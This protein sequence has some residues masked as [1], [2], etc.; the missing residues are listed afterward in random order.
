MAV[1]TAEV[2]TYEPRG[3]VLDAFYCHDKEV[4]L[5][6]PAGTGKTLGTLQKLHLCAAHRYPGCR[7]LIMRKTLTSLTRSALVTFQKTVKPHLDGV[8]FFG[9][10]ASKPPAFQYPNGSEIVV[11]GMDKPEN[12]LSAEYDAV[13]INQA[14]ELDESE[15]EFAKM[16]LRPFAM[17]YAQ[18]VGDCNPAAPTHWIKRRAER[19]IIADE[20][21][22]EGQRQL[23]LLESRHQDNPRY[24]DAAAQSWTDEGRSYV[25]GTLGSLTGVRALRY[26][27]GL[28]AAA[29]GL[30]YDGWEPSVNLIAPFD[31]PADWGRVW[32][33][34]FGYVHA[35][36]WQE[37]R[38]DG[39]G[40]MYR[41]KEIHM[42]QRLVADHAL[43]IARAAGA[44]VNAEAPA[45]KRID[46]TGVPRP[47]SLV[48]DHDAED[49][50]TLER[51]LG[52]P[53][54]PA[55][56]AIGKGVQAFAQRLK[57]AGDGRPRLMFFRDALVELDQSAEQAKKP[58]CTEQEVDGYVWPTP[59]AVSR[60]ADEVPVKKDDDGLDAARYAVMHEDGGHIIPALPI[61]GAF[62]RTSPWSV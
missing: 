55:K 2:V 49:R 16:R 61:V 20:Q 42:T 7:I 40:R 46:W 31:V 5:S 3:A 43:D 51:E 50:A 12:V 11:G 10:S 22:R 9:G 1:A 14:E 56:K 52:M 53:T 34:D 54:L 41:T 62:E 57:P 37:W 60:A 17:L 47:Q 45:G 48:C 30:V 29:E 6:G 44:R 59:N 8:R 58:T 15:W 25:L 36:V 24:W 39:D 4:M 32:T 26:A 21:L 13:Y 27:R 28:W 18:L 33:V 23:T 19:A 38:I 35:F